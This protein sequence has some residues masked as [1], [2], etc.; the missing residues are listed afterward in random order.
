MKK[1][2]YVLLARFRKIT[3]VVLSITSFGIIGFPLAAYSQSVEKEDFPDQLE[4]HDTFP[5]SE[6]EGSLLDMSN[7]MDLMQRIRQKTAMEDATSPSDAI[8]EALRAL[9][10]MEIETPLKE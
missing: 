5:T 4:I 8:D 10:A 2:T 7:Q 1:G 3:S 6:N 9:D